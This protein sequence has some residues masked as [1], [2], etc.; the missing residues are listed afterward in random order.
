MKSF[1][2]IYAAL[3]VNAVQFT[4]NRY[5]LRDDTAEQIALDAF[6]DLHEALQKDTEIKNPEAW[7]RKRILIHHVE[8]VRYEHRKKR[9]GEFAR[10]GLTTNHPDLAIEH[11]GFKAV[12]AADTIQSIWHRLTEA[13][14]K[15][16]NMVFMQE[17]NQRQI[18]VQLGVTLRTVE[19]HVSQVRNRLRTLLLSPS[20]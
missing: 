9:G 12:D 5:N 17:L 18:A 15:I 3:Y 19:R 4:R 8:H 20:P 2:E 10:H 1:N 7:L 13:E 11:P 14:Q 6:V 16:A